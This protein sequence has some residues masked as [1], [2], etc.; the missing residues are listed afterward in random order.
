MTE[1]KDRI[2]TGGKNPDKDKNLEER[3]IRKRKRELFVSTMMIVYVIIIMMK[4][5]GINF[6][7][8]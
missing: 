6:N 7:H 4:K 8:V 2:P 5:K 1:K 3:K